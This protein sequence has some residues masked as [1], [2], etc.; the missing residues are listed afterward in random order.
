VVL[1]DLDR[2]F[3]EMMDSHPDAIALYDEEERFVLCNERYRQDQQDI[4][5]LFGTGVTFEEI[6]RANAETTFNALVVAEETTLDAWM[7][8]R[9]RLFRNPGAPDIRHYKD[10][11]WEKVQDIETPSGGRLIIR[12]DITAQKTAENELRDSEAILKAIIDIVPSN[13]NVKDS[14]GRYLLNNKAHA[15]LFGLEGVDVRGKTSGIIS[16]A[17]MRNV[18][19]LDRRVL[20]MGVSVASHDYSAVNRDGEARQLLLAKEPLKDSSG[21]VIGVVTA[22]VDITERKRLE[23]EVK[24]LNET[25]EQRVADRTRELNLQIE[26]QAETET[27]LRQSEETFRNLVDGSLQGIRITDLNGKVLF[28]NQTH[29]D[30][31]GYDSPDEILS[32]GLLTNLAAPHER[33]R[34]MGYRRA[35]LRGKVLPDSYEFDGLHKD[36][37]ALRIQVMPRRVVWNGVP[38]SQLALLDVTERWRAEHSLSDSLAR[39]QAIFDNVA[40]AIIGLD[41]SGRIEA[42]N[43]SGA[44]MFGYQV[45]ELKG[46]N[47]DIL[48]PDS[49]RDEHQGYL[50]RY[51]QSGRSDPLGGLSREYFGLRK[52]GSTFPISLSVNEFFENERRMF[53]GRIRDVTESKR[54]E[55][56][57]RGSEMRLRDAVES[58]PASFLLFDA[59]DR[60]VIFNEKTLDLM[61]WQRGFLKP[62]V[63]Y[64]EML[65]NAIDK[66]DLAIP[67]G[68][69]EAW[70]KERV[71]QHL[72]P[73]LPVESERINGGW[74]LTFDR[75]TPE[76][77]IVSIRLDITDRKRIEHDL[78]DA[79]VEA[80]RA[81]RVKSEF[82]A[83]M[84]H[85]LRTPLNAI[86]GFSEMLSEQFYGNL[87][88]PRYLE[89]SNDI[90]TSGEHLLQLVNDVLDL[91]AIEAGQQ[92]IFREELKFKDIVEDCAPIV[93]NGAAQKNIVYSINVPDDLPRLWADKRAVKQI[94]LNILTNAIKFTPDGGKVT[95][96][97][98]ATN[99]AIVVD[100]TDTGIGVSADK[101]D[102][103]TEPFVRGE[104]DPYKSQEGMGLGLSIVRS[105]VILHGGALE[106]NSEVGVGT[107]VIATF[108]LRDD[109]R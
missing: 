94:L 65:R 102:S 100:V 93:P 79:L 66:G 98:Y 68:G 5:G 3:R 75:K 84:S 18:A 70:I 53:I 108:P 82:L 87:G 89:Y 85:E 49:H 101:L 26:K 107:T 36:G 40:D 83:T 105:L 8:N 48:M 57:L 90:R 52:D 16:D 55:D 44:A 71:V 88:S 29:A 63:R 17:Q 28:V 41:D 31:F 61:P 106:I 73:S 86:I 78:R 99:A 27:A 35:R 42:I 2:H 23:S 69:E 81:N 30:I 22:S 51:L 1:S 15:T 97:A 59:E 6:L 12:S 47:V 91:S 56:A 34:L 25:L 24:A 13:I 14:Q 7:E 32:K 39:L 95:L 38:A 9:L 72:N 54:S 58:M 43:S 92:Q 45:D 80:E 76:G 104:T 67:S 19:P 46:R 96:S 77:G 103:L 60:L 50:Q 20:E 64:E 11:R 37:S 74:V 33:Q 62:G 10:G 109:S 21:K 4:A